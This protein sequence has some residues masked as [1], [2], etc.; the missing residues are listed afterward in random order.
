MEPVSRCN[1][2][3]GKIVQEQESSGVLHGQRQAFC[4][5]LVHLSCQAA[6]KETVRRG[7]VDN[8]CTERDFGGFREKDRLGRQLRGD[9]SRND[10]LPEE[11]I[12]EIQP[13]DLSEVKEGSGI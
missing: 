9:S 13:P 2:A 1:L 4:L 8:V 11:A 7:H 6:D 3:G 5:P 10:Y 12:D